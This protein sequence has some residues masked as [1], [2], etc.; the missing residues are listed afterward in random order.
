M[1]LSKLTQDADLQALADLMAQKW[2]QDVRGSDIQTDL[3][4]RCFYPYVK[5]EYYESISRE[6]KAMCKVL[7]E[8]DEVTNRMLGKKLE[9]E[10]ESNLERYVQFFAECMIDAAWERDVESWEEKDLS[11]LLRPVSKSIFRDFYHQIVYLRCGKLCERLSAMG[12]ERTPENDGILAYGYI[13]RQAGLSFRG[14][15]CAS[16]DSDGQMQ[17]S[18]GKENTIMV[19]RAG[20]VEDAMFFNMMESNCDLSAFLPIVEMTMCYDTD[21][22][23]LEGMRYFTSLDKF[24][25]PEY[26]D[27]VKVLLWKEGCSVEEVWVRC[28]TLD[29]ERKMMI[30]TLLNEPSQNFGCH[31]GDDI[32]FYSYKENDEIC[33]CIHECE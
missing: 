32:P 25:H 26:P 23:Y 10:L 28:A 30:G 4:R 7:L 11:Q 33:F 12:F 5:E 13:D 16:I 6:V 31:I 20:F 21:N 29:Y 3:K 24:R 9:Q 2:K 15:C 14:L 1:K 17:L 8:S 19:F 22:A 27:D 18:P